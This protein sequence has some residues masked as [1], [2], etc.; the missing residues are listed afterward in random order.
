MLVASGAQPG[1]QLFAV[2]QARACPGR[3]RLEL[4]GGGQRLP[5]GGVPR[6]ASRCSCPVAT[7]IPPAGGAAGAPLPRG[8]RRAPGGEAPSELRGPRVHSPGCAC[9]AAAGGAE[10]AD[11]RATSGHRGSGEGET[12]TSGSAASRGPESSGVL[13]VM[14]PFFG[15]PRGTNV[16][17]RCF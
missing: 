3:G 11:C 5:G 1:D 15:P 14:S 7:V 10:V 2:P 6:C 4:L 13:W 12:G 8:Y 9:I 17:K 16:R